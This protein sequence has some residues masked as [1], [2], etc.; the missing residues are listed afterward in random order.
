MLTV[1]FQNWLYILHRY[2]VILQSMISCSAAHCRFCSESADVAAKNPI[3]GPVVV[4][5][6]CRVLEFGQLTSKP[7]PEFCS[8]S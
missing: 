5:M 1:E 8:S 6:W 4:S 3:N 2:S 7:V